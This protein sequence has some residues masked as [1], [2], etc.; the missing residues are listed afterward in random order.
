MLRC[1]SNLGIPYRCKLFYRVLLFIYLLIHQLLCFFTTFQ[2]I[3]GLFYWM[4]LN[5]ERHVFIHE[6]LT[7]SSCLYSQYCS[8][9]LSTAE[10]RPPLERTTLL[11]PLLSPSSAHGRSC[12]C[13]RTTGSEVVSR[14]AYRD[15]VSTLDDRYD[16]LTATSAC[17]LHRII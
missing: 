13:R 14:Y 1:K 10:H 5:V 16:Q 11:G 3:D 15:A 9:V 12:E 2:F 8:P 4:H 6:V 7:S 17:F